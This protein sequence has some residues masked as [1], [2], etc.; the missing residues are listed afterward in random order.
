MLELFPKTKN[1][2]KPSSLKNMLKEVPVAEL[3]VF[4]KTFFSRGYHFN[5]LPLGKTEKKLPQLSI[6]SAALY[7]T[8]RW[9]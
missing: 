3:L 8:S 6:F 2:F 5:L 4:A 9:L 7:L 1:D